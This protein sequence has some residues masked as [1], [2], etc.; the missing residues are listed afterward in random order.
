M[1]TQKG[2]F[3]EQTKLFTAPEKLD[4]RRKYYLVLDCETATLPLV[5]EFSEKEQRKLS[6]AK[7][8]IYDL[9]WKIVDCIGRVYSRHSYLISEIFSVPQIF[10][11]AYYADK[12]P[13]YLEKLR[14]GETILTDWRTAKAVLIG[15]MV[16]VNAVGAYNAMFDFKKAIPF[17]D[18]YIDMLYSPYYYQWEAE[19]RRI[20]E[21]IVNTSK[22]NDSTENCFEPEIFRW[23]GTVF[24]LFDLWGLTCKHLL[25]CDEYRKLCETNNW[26]TA[27][28]KYYKTSAETAYRFIKGMNDFDEAHMAIEDADIESELLCAIVKEKRANMEYGI[29]YF[30]FKMVGTTPEE[31]WERV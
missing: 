19:Q 14:N 30:P 28:K 1:P 7:P 10:N 31:F 12:R 9:G 11:T 25:N 15:D 26:V 17:T 8:L 23:G 20:C 5:K 3:M 21:R 18:L 27:S 4:R 2:N 22:K 13:I 29:M 6:I 24:P 16:K